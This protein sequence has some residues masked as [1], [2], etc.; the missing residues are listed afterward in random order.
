MAYG[1][2]IIPIVF[3]GAIE[4]TGAPDRGLYI[5]VAYYAISLVVLWVFYLRRGAP[6]HGA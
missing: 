3:K 1:A 5:F 2:F 6:E 4:S